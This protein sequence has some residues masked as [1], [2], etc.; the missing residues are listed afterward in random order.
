MKE[1]LARMTLREKI[2][3][4]MQLSPFFF[5]ADLEKEAAGP[6]RDLNLDEDKIFAAGTALGIGDAD[7]MI[8]V[9]RRYLKKNR[10]GIPLLFGADVIHGY[11]TIFPVP[12]AL[13]CSWNPETVR[14]ASRIAA[15]EASVAG[16]HM[17]YAPMA[18]L[19]RDPRW[20]RVV[21]SFGEDPLLLALFARAAVEGFQGGDLGGDG[22][23]A[24]CVKHFA[25]YGAPEGGREYNTVDLSRQSLE[26]FYFAGYRAAV[27]AGCRGVMT[28]FN[29]IEAVPCTINRYLLR[30]VLRDRWG[31]RGVTLTD[32][33]SLH[34]T[35]AHGAAEDER[36][37]ARRG[38]EAGL[39]IEM[40]STDY[41]N[42]LENLVHDGIVDVRLIDEAALRVLELKRDLGLFD[43][44]FRNADPE[45]EKTVMLSPAHRAA[46]RRAAHE[47]AVL[48]KNDGVLPLGRGLRL[49]L[50]G[51]FAQSGETNGPWS[52]H[53]NGARN[54]TLADVLAARGFDLV[55]VKTG[56]SPDDYD[57]ADREAIRR[58]DVVLLALGESAHQ[59]GEA[60]ARADVTLPGRQA[61]LVPFVSGLGRK[62]V[63]LLQN[64]RPLVL[65]NVLAADAILETWFLGT[66][67]APAIADLLAGDVN[68][69][70]RLTMSFPRA[71]GQIPVHYDELP[72]GRPNLD[73]NHPGEYVTKYVDLPNSPRFPFG[74]GLGYARFDYG[75]VR[76]VTPSS[77]T[78]AMSVTVAVD[79]TNAGAVGGVETVQCYL[80]DH[81]ARISR[82]VRELKGFRRIA[83]APGE[84]ATVRFTLGLADLSYRLA[85]GS[86]VWDPGLFTV[87]VGPNAATLQGASF[88]LVR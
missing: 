39:D 72:T 12:L 57:V 27:E 51:P 55:L 8:R 20:G 53:G 87:S 78:S 22:S 46:A 45:R 19:V 69:S 30:D 1:L 49:A 63:I 7:E 33:D 60:H 58:A 88:R 44:P 76:L 29:P 10:L 11:R 85:D 5:V 52:W 82:P 84:T 32:Y 48:L 17:T 2:G 9:Q 68:P 3:Q 35:I 31:F 13:S 65:E 14:E 61:E 26:S 83:L 21:E 36:D 6:I 4:L 34:E 64:G 18:D 38:I 75:P 73:E 54:A 80:R 40:A 74:F 37:A 71:V 86:L 67:A 42:H 81:A 15:R 28:A 79:V 50:L 16:V 77:I 70:G 24:A 59:S 62:A 41:V 56:A 43:D 47:A 66:E 25:G 23:V